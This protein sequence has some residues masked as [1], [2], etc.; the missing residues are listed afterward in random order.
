[1]EIDI[2]CFV[3][4]EEP[5]EY[6]ASAAERGANAGPETWA[7]AKRQAEHKPMLNTPEQLDAMRQWMKETGAWDKA[8]RD[9]MT[10]EDLNALFIQLVSG[11]MRE[12][13]LDDEFPDEFD[14]EAYRERSDGGGNIYVGDIEGHEGFGRWFYN[15]SS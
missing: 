11:D 9:A 8:E 12:M 13:G 5:S 1:M 14:W 6:S 2:T 4:N 15:L 3:K 7:N 10:D